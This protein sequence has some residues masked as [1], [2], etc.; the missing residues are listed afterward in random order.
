[1][2]LDPN[3]LPRS[4]TKDA[5]V[6]RGERQ[7]LIP[8]AHFCALPRS[9]DA[10]R[11]SLG[12]D[13][14]GV[15]R[16][17]LNALILHNGLH[18]HL[19]PP[20]KVTRLHH[21]LCYWSVILHERTWSRAVPVTW[22]NLSTHDGVVRLLPSLT[23]FSSLRVEPPSDLFFIHHPFSTSRSHYFSS[24]GFHLVAAVPGPNNLAYFVA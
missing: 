6:D 9:I 7:D 17:H 3:L 8:G 24:A 21:V 2:R 18:L 10:W 1:M 15:H 14:S 22:L 20:L 12:S 16:G 11:A 4:A 5:P 19:Q 23:I 13:C